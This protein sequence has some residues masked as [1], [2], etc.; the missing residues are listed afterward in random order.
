MN[1]NNLGKL[2]PEEIVEMLVSNLSECNR[3]VAALS[4]KSGLDQAD[5]RKL[6]NEL[7]FARTKVRNLAKTLDEM[8][9]PVNSFKLSS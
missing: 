4:K 2:T 1:T 8:K 9:K 7:M 5:L 3:L 6:R